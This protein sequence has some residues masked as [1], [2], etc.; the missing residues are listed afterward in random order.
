MPVCQDANH[1]FSD[2]SRILP[3]A[4]DFDGNATKYGMLIQFHISPLSLL[5]N[6]NSRIDW[7]VDKGN[8]INTNSSGGALGMILTESNGGTRLS[9]TRYVHYGTITARGWY[10]SLD[11]HPHCLTS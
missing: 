6:R 2:N 4:T 1:T 5:T 10:M 11:I 9:S 3:N 8:I 7:V